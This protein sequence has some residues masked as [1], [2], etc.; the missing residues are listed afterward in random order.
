MFPEVTKAYSCKFQ[1]CLGPSSFWS[2]YVSSTFRLVK[3]RQYLQAVS[4]NY[5]Q[6]IYTKLSISLNLFT[7]VY[8]FK[9]FS[10]FSI[11][12]MV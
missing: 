2:S 12:V 11:F 5:F 7:Y 8:K 6:I 9:Y 4:F 1:D 3:K 10:D